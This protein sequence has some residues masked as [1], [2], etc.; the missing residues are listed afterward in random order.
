MP[1]TTLGKRNVSQPLEKKREK[2]LLIS[3]GKYMYSILG[4]AFVAL[5]FCLQ[6]GLRGVKFLEREMIEIL[7]VYT[8]LVLPS[9]GTHRGCHFLFP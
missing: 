7:S 6:G 2:L 8:Q 3:F 1:G 4:N 5:K 9:F